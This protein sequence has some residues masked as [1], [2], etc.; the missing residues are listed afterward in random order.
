[1]PPQT[2]HACC[3]P[4]R[5]SPCV[6]NGAWM[7][8]DQALVFYP[9][10]LSR[11]DAADSS[12]LSSRRRISRHHDPGPV[13]QPTGRIASG[14]AESVAFGARPA[15]REDE[16]PEWRQMLILAAVRRADEVS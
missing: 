9:T 12:N 8:K 11:I 13:A 2:R 3:G 15:D 7:L 14:H 5:D 10:Q 16:H 6:Q 4:V 1:M